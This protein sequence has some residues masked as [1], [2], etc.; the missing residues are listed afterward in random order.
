MDVLIKLKLPL[1]I[2]KSALYLGC[3]FG[4]CLSFFCLAKMFTSITT[5]EGGESFLAENAL[6]LHVFVSSCI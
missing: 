1:A 3:V 2:P 6:N 5:R 4:Q